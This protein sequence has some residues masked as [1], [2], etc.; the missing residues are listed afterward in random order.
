MK[1]AISRIALVD[2]VLTRNQMFEIAIQVERDGAAFYEKAADSD[3]LCAVR[4]VL[5]ELVE[6]EKEH[7]ETFIELR[8]G[9]LNPE[10]ARRWNNPKSPAVEYM[11]SFSRGKVF[12]LTQD[13]CQYLT[14]GATREQLL[15]FAIDRELDT[16]AFFMGLMSTMS[17]SYGGSRKV[18]KII[19]EEMEHV[20]L[21]VGD[22]TARAKKS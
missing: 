4:V 3:A 7:E 10:E 18:E 8:Q 15:R 21:L 14:P 1:K 20:N 17:S 11:K 2:E 6:M 19:K 22:L 9:S 12:D 13:L 5:L 16:I